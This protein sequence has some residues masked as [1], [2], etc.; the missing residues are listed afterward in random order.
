MCGGP[1]LPTR[2]VRTVTK[3]AVRAMITRYRVAKIVRTRGISRLIG[4]LRVVA[5]PCQVSI[6]EPGHDFVEDHDER[7]RQTDVEFPAVVMC[8]PHD[9]LG[10]DLGL[11]DGRHWLPL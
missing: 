7:R 4:L 11:V 5:R 10:G 3:A 6:G 8:C 9:G 1:Q 2:F